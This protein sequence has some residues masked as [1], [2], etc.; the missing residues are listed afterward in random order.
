[1][2]NGTQRSM[3][4]QALMS[5][6]R[7]WFSGLNTFAFIQFARKPYFIQ[8]NRL[9]SCASNN[10]VGRQS[11]WFLVRWKPLPL[12]TGT[13][14][15]HVSSVRVCVRVCVHVCVCVVARV[16][17]FW[18]HWSQPVNL[19]IRWPEPHLLQPDDWFLFGAMPMG[20]IKSKCKLSLIT[21]CKENASSHPPLRG[22]TWI[23]LT[24]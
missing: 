18:L 4:L 22:R 11:L 13:I 21:N 10:H 2:R 6:G 9:P 12:W 5:P 1:M 24:S 20:L 16:S 7:M 19:F 3:A 23:T 15:P 8:V 14:V 17:Y